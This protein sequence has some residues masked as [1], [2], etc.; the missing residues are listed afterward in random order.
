VRGVE[1]RRE[2]TNGGGGGA[3]G[4]PHLKSGEGAAK[5][6]RAELNPKRQHTGTH[7]TE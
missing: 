3:A 5:P 6:D 1:D 4:F 7:F 2:K